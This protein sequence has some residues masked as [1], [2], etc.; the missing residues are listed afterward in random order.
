M[1][2]TE[3]PILD[4]DSM[5]FDELGAIDSQVP[6]QNFSCIWRAPYPAEIGLGKVWGIY[7]SQLWMGM[8]RL[9][10]FS[11]YHLEDTHQL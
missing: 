11:L 5:L 9:K 10:M 4:S 2:L 1:A 3:S 6:A 7:K 8:S